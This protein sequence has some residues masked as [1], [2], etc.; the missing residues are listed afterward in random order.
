MSYQSQQK[1]SAHAAMETIY[2]KSYMEKVKS[3]DGI[4]VEI[5]PYL[6]LVP[7]SGIKADMP[8]L[9]NIVSGN[10]PDKGSRDPINLC[11]VLDRSGSMGG[12][13]LNECK[14]GI[15]LLL[16]KLN[17]DDYVH[18]VVYDDKIETVFEGKHLE[19]LDEMTAL[20]D[21]IQS[22]NMTNISGAL[23]SGV[24]LLK[25]YGEVQHKKTIFLFSDGEANH[26]VTDVDE[27][28]GMVHTWQQTDNINF[29]TFGI[30]ENYNEKLMKGIARCGKGLYTYLDDYEKTAGYVR[31]ALFNMTGE[32]GHNAVLTVRGIGN[33]YVKKIMFSDDITALVK[34]KRIGD[35]NEHNVVQILTH[36][37]Y[38]PNLANNGTVLQYSLTFD[39]IDSVELPNPSPIKGELRMGTTDNLSLIEPNPEVEGYLAIRAGAELELKVSEYIS[40]GDYDRAL[41]TKEELVGLYRENLGKCKFVMVDM[42][43]SKAMTALEALK[44]EGLSA[45]VVK[46]QNYYGQMAYAAGG[47]SQQAGAVASGAAFRGVVEEEADALEGGMDMFG[48]DGGDY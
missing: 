39:K 28:G 24:T 46:K 14:R 25:K 45:N 47:I 8:V 44:S 43:W 12:K 6:N 3:V 42:L 10:I 23:E 9:F 37:E 41:K 2:N 11:L 30:G 15:T 5:Y 26:G 31:K 1:A 13:W 19:D 4:S 20:V 7:S 27:I 16:G 17:K 38:D 32:M 48:G 21:S 34:G 18:L 22:R 35:L 36:I 29:T 40:Q 33:N